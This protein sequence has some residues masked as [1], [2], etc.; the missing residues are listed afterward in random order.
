MADQ[1]EAAKIWNEM[2]VLENSKPGA[3]EDKDSFFNNKRKQMKELKDAYDAA[4][5]LTN[6]TTSIDHNEAA[7]NR[8]IMNMFKGKKEMPKTKDSD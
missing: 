4:T 7:S 5:G 8:K 3:Q 6:P 2:V 1:R